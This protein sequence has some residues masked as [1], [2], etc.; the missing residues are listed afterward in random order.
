MW[1]LA[2]AETLMLQ[3][4]LDYLMVLIEDYKNEIIFLLDLTANC[5]QMCLLVIIFKWDFLDGLKRFKSNKSMIQIGNLN[6]RG[7]KKHSGLE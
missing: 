3:M 5:S 6:T 4:L 1:R 7:W 2:A